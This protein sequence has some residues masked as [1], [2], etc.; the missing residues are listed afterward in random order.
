VAK[1]KKAVKSMKCP[2]GHELPR[3]VRGGA[4]CTPLDCADD[5][6]ALVKK[7]E[8]PVAI[9]PSE[10]SDDEALK[11]RR[12]IEIRKTQLAA[13]RGVVELPEGL[14]GEAA[15]KWA[16]KK[17]VELLPLAVSELEYQLKYGSDEQRERATAKVLDA[18][19]RGK[20]E[21]AV[22]ANQ[23]IIINFPG[24]QAALPWAQRVDPKKVG[25]GQ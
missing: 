19:G 14:E 24:G 8:V 6:K 5:V 1:S 18:N 25:D 12:K 7:G 23:Q 10:D 20:A 17:I 11:E 21:K 2:K 9:V 13:R 22:G 4:Q 16:D 3:T 15:E